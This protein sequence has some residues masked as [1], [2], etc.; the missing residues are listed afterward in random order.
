MW[1]RHKISLSAFR[2]YALKARDKL[3]KREREREEEYREERRARARE[4]HAHHRSECVLVCGE[5]Q[6]SSTYLV[7]VNRA[8]LTGR[9]AQLTQLVAL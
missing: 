2:M 7:S 1:V 6:T 3:H 5:N 4:Q 8:R 9:H